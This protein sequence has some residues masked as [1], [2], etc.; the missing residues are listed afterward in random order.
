MFN[1]DLVTSVVFNIELFIIVMFN[2]ELFTRVVARNYC[3]VL[4]DYVPACQINCCTLYDCGLHII[5][6]IRLWITYHLH[7]KIM[8]YISSTL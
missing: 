2:M 3:P 1:I 5:Y 4:T 7:C 6:I 8:G